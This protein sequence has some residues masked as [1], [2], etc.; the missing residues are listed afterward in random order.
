[1][2]CIARHL[3]NKL[4]FLNSEFKFTE[5]LRRHFISQVSW[6]PMIS[7]LL[8]TLRKFVILI[9]SK[10][11][12]LNLENKWRAY[13]LQSFKWF[14]F[15]SVGSRIIDWT[16]CTCLYWLLSAS[17]IQNIEFYW[18][19]DYRFVLPELIYAF[20]M[21]FHIQLCFKTIFDI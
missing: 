2:F 12:F 14:S 9:L 11:T 7:D 15:V 1:M 6:E 16:E 17:F 3:H 18:L 20:I 21:Y 13:E 5:N 19:M 10:F 4:R 8:W